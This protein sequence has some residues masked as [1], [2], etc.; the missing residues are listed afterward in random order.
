M[1][2]FQNS[3]FCSL[4]VR[5]WDLVC[6]L[7]R[8]SCL[9]RIIDR[10]WRF[11][12]RGLLYHLLTC[13]S[14]LERIW[15][16][17]FFYKALCWVINLI[18]NL[19]LRLYERIRPA[20]DGSL[21]CRFLRFLGKNTAALLGLMLLVLLVVPQALWNNLYSLLM[22]LACLAVFW[23]R[24]G[25]ER[26]WRLRP[27]LIGPWPVLFAL[28][29]CLSFLWSQDMALSFRF[30]FFNLTCILVVL[31]MVSSV[32]TEKQLNRVV[33]LLALGLG[34][35]CLYAVYQR[36]S[37]IEPNSSFTDL[38]V[39]AKMPGRVFSFFEN[40]NA[41]ANIL[42]FFTPTM[43]A[44]IFYSKKPWQRLGFAGAAALCCL[45]L[46]M[47]YSRGGWLSLAFSVFILMLLLCPRWVPLLLLA[48]A[49]LVPFLPRNILARLL[50]IFS[51]DSSISSRSYIYSAMVRLIR[52]NWF[53]GVGLGTTTLKRGIYYYGVFSAPILIFIHA[54]NI[55]LEIW[56]ESGVLAAIAFVLTI[57]FTLRK[58]CA[59]VKKAAPSPLRGI[60]AGSVSGLF[61]SMFFGLTDYAWSYPRVLV[62]FWFLFAIIYAAIKL[63]EKKE[64]SNNG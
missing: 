15:T 40:P 6:R 4:I 33:G 32:E 54:H 21:A 16:E 42:V 31:L 58:G 14:R 20:A 44:M 26:R 25:A 56:G 38:D 34:L 36:L 8:E 35:C 10:L 24:G 1:T 53:F 17:S 41:F 29:S 28:I 5:F 7:Y 59:A 12:K 43:I 62:L 52:Q 50:S 60:L 48:G 22:A 51:S 2:I 55:L 3:F 37:G 46:V 9:A 49:A 23:F 45:S 63:A 13:D 19:L 27:D 64:G 39:N 61:G 47:T 18:P 30:L 11:W 57:F